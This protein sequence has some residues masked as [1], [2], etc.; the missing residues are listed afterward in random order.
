[1]HKQRGIWLWG[2]LGQFLMTYRKKKRLWVLLEPIFQNNPTT[3]IKELFACGAWFGTLK[4]IQL[5]INVQK[6]Q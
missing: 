3:Q 1:M 5:I 2:D 4:G 6:L